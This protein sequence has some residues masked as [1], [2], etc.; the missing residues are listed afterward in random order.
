MSVNA[1][2]ES[3]EY[4]QLFHSAKDL[5]FKGVLLT[6][7]IFGIGYYNI[8]KNKIAAA[9]IFSMKA[10]QYPPS[11]ID[12]KLLS[13]KFQRFAEF[14]LIDFHEVNSWLVTGSINFV[15]PITGHISAVQY[16]PVFSEQRDV[17]FFILM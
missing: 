7:R 14:S 10:V 16:L 2:F 6:E 5:S 8:K 11:W 15:N 12:L 17:C 1:R 9:F 13:Y 3:S 4:Q